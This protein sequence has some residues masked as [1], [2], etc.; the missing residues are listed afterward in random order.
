MSIFLSIAITTHKRNDLLFECLHSIFKSIE[1]YRSN[2]IHN[3]SKFEILIFDDNP[4]Q[5]L[6]F[7]REILNNFKHRDLLTHL[8]YK[9]NQVNLGDYFNRNQAVR[10]ANGVFLKYIDDDDIIYENT[11]GIIYFSIKSFDFK[12]KT[13]LFYLRDNFRHLNFPVILNSSKNIFDF[14]YS[15]YGIFHCSLVS[16]VFPTDIL[17]DIKGF[18]CKRFYGDFEILNR[19]S[20]LSEIAIFP[21][22]LGFYRAHDNQESKMNRENIEIRFNYILISINVFIENNLNYDIRK[23]LINDIFNFLKGGVKRLNFNLIYN[24]L[25]LFYFLRNEK[26]S[27]GDYLMWKEYFK[28]KILIFGNQINE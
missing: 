7:K 2:Y 26:L 3:D 14:H 24:S 5:S 4:D 28:K 27:P 17:K 20:L 21:N 9:I 12:K 10:E 11:I 16:V 25:I 19:I 6:D 13:Y 8:E 23:V 15:K 22:E 1:F 18:F